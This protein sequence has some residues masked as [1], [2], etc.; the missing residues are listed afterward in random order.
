MRLDATAVDD[1]D[2]TGTTYGDVWNDDDDGTY[3]PVGNSS[4]SPDAR[5]LLD[6]YGGDPITGM[7]VHFRASATGVVNQPLM[8]ELIRPGPGFGTMMTFWGG[9]S[10]GRASKPIFWDAP[11]DWDIP[12]DDTI[13]DYSVAVDQD[14]LDL[15]G[16][17]ALDELRPDLT[18]GGCFLYLWADGFYADEPPFPEGEIRIYEAWLEIDGTPLISSEIGQ[19]RRIFL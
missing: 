17:D 15:R 2:D 18:D 4:P 9:A 3:A 13:R 12:N 8:V 10:T 16:W 11:V 19:K 5:G 7:S 6:T 14:M 1:F